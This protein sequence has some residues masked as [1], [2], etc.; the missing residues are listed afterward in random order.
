MTENAWAADFAEMLDG[1]AA[2]ARNEGIAIVELRHVFEALALSPT[3]AVDHVMSGAG[4]R[5]S[6]L[7]DYLDRIRSYKWRDD[8]YVPT[9]DVLQL[10]GVIAGPLRPRWAWRP[11]TS[12][13]ADLTV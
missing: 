3:S 12:E 6:F 9:V 7:R 2:I 13:R 8:A 11:S 1:A 5:P 4:L 10:A